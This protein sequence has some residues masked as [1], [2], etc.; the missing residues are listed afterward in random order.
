MGFLR[1]PTISGEWQR[2]KNSEKQRVQT[3][4]RRIGGTDRKE[5]V[6]WFFREKW[7]KWVFP[8]LRVSFFSV[9]CAPHRLGSWDLC[10]WWPLKK[11]KLER[12]S[13]TF[14]CAEPEPFKVEPL[15]KKEEKQEAPDW[16]IG[17]PSHAGHVHLY[18]QVSLHSRKTLVRPSP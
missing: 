18:Q 1:Y 7:F 12:V 9:S 10:G 14:P 2:H 8:F 15:A 5:L 11:Q 6:L 4:Y 17:W 13:W 16:P 3:A